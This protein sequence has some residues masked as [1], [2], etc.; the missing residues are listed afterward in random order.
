MG[1]NEKKKKEKI[2]PEINTKSNDT[3]EMIFDD[4]VFSIFLD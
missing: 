2:Q 3:K 1:N 4:F